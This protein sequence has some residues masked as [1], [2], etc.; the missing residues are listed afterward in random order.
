MISS[1][2][3]P[4][5]AYSFHSF[6]DEPKV[7]E[8]IVEFLRKKGSAPCASSPFPKNLSDRYLASFFET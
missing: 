7:S 1:L 5:L 2:C 6:R 4:H 3:C 8:S